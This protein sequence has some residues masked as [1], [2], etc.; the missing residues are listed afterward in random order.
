VKSPPERT[1]RQC[2]KNIT[3][4]L[5][6]GLDELMESIENEALQIRKE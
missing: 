1:D 4:L 2:G 3:K 5:K 6:H